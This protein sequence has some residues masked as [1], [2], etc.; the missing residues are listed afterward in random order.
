MLVKGKV[1]YVP[2]NIRE[3]NAFILV[4]S[5]SALAPYPAIPKT[6]DIRPPL[7]AIYFVLEG[8]RSWRESQRTQDQ[9]FNIAIV[10]PS[11]S[12][13]AR[14]L[15]RLCHHPSLRSSGHIVL[16][17]IARHHYAEGLPPRQALRRPGADSRA[18]RYIS[19]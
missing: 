5:A 17:D 3:L 18:E 4:V 13:A 19:H 15:P 14:R 10:N 8:C 6:S 9:L 12:P 7:S 16:R 11:H 1:K 2:M